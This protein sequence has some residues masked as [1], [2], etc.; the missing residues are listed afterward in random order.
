MAAASHCRMA[1]VMIAVN[2]APDSLSGKISPLSPIR[3]RDMVF[4]KIDDAL[5]NLYRH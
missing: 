5:H 3:L 1:D 4:K 2:L